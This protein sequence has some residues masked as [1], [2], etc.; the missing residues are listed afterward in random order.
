MQYTLADKGYPRYSLVGDHQ[1]L[2]DPEL[3]SEKIQPREEEGERSWMMRLLYNENMLHGPRYGS[4]RL[5][6]STL[7]HQSMCI[8]RFIV[9]N[10]IIDANS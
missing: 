1:D 10:N 7:R 8:G 3:R 6:R 9:E 2:S 4:M 5:K